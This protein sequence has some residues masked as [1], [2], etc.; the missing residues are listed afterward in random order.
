MELLPKQVQKLLLIPQLQQAMQ[1]L[2]LPTME[3]RQ[4]IQKELLENPFLEEVKEEENP[5]SEEIMEEFLELDDNW[6]EYF[7]ATQMR[8]EVPES[9]DL[10]QTLESREPSLQEILLR[11]LQMQGL[12]GKEK[13]IGEVIIANINEDGFLT[14]SLEEISKLLRVPPKKVEKV[15]SLI[16]TFDPPG[17]GARDLKECLLL[18]LKEKGEKDPLIE[19]IISEYLEDV[20]KRRYSY[21]AQKLGVKEE[22]VREV[23]QKI[24]SLEPR[25]GRK[26]SS[27]KPFFIV[28]DVVVKKINHEYRVILNDDFLPSLRINPY[29]RK[30]LRE[31]K[32]EGGDYQF[33]TRK[34]RDAVWL[35]KNIQGRQE[36][37]RRVAEYIVERQ[38]EFL[39]KGVEYLKP[40]TLK[41]V[42]EALGVH[43]STVSRVTSRKFIET[44][45]GIFKMKYF[46]SGSARG[47]KTEVS[48]RSIK[49]SIRQII[50]SED[51]AHP[52]SD[53][54]IAS[55]LWQKGFKIARR[56]VA[57]YREELG[58]L[59]SR[60]RRS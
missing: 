36:I 56:T 46:F 57:K 43:P 49:E 14:V 8:K 29:Y 51:P 11:Q 48:T 6:Q 37:V 27:L 23:S 39:E 54:E 24:A 59:P 16:Q 17:V 25:P 44:P 19:K 53:E 22:K 10:I 52:F 18:Q 35:I 4:F 9:K 26:Y 30:I 2:Q 50:E 5:S 34:L 13:E 20:G 42:A 60:L 1:V 55:L 47:D 40:L 33:L 58:I 7:Q 28:P 15:L 31:G 32:K 38:K 3:L 45:R 41:D 12:K 21:I